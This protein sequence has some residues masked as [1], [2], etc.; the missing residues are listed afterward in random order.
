MSSFISRLS[1]EMSNMG[2]AFNDAYGNLLYGDDA[3]KAAKLV[4]IANP[5]ISSKKTSSLYYHGM[6]FIEVN[7]R[8]YV[9]SVDPKSDAHRAGVKPRD[10]VQLAL[11]LG[12]SLNHLKNNNTEAAK[13][14]LECEKDGMRT[15]CTQLK[16][17]IGESCFAENPKALDNRA[18]QE[19]YY[20]QS[21]FI[22]ITPDKN[23]N[24]S[25]SASVKIRHGVTHFM[26][27]CGGNNT[28]NN[29][30]ID[31]DETTSQQQLF[32]SPILF[33]LRRTRQRVPS[34][35]PTS[36]GLVSFRLDDECDRAADFIHRLA[37]TTLDSSSPSKTRAEIFYD[38]KNWFLPPLSTGTSTFNRRKND[39]ESEDCIK[40]S[41]EKIDNLR[42]IK[43]A[44]DIITEESSKE[45]KR[46]DE[47]ETKAIRALIQTAVGLAFIRTSKFVLGV[48]LNAGSGI[49]IARLPDGTWSPPSALGMMGAGLGLQFGLE[50]VDYIFILQTRQSLDN[51]RRGGHFTVGGNVG[52][53]VAGLGREAYGA[54]SLGGSLCAPNTPPTDNKHD[55]DSDDDMTPPPTPIAEFSHVM[56]YAKSQGLYFGV[57]LEG[58]RI[59]TRDDLN[60][61]SYKFSTGKFVHAYDVLDG[62][63][64]IPPEA[65]NLYASLHSLEYNHEISDLPRPPT[66]LREF[67]CKD[68]N[69]N[70]PSPM[71]S[72][73]KSEI[74]SLP[75]FSS[76]SEVE[77]ADCLDFESKIKD[78]L[79]GGVSVLRLIPGSEDKDG[80]TRCQ[81]RT[82]WL[83]EP[84]QGTLR[85]GFISKG[86]EE[87]IAPRQNTVRFY[88]QF[89]F[90]SFRL[91]L[92]RFIT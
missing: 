69:C 29:D 36:A 19:E 25:P 35:S 65:E 55:D 92:T 71:S 87:G 74:P 80:M 44:K 76:L 24:N 81:R 23:R 2:N 15:S 41:N 88:C 75:F 46:P 17:I 43:L 57:S 61:R 62:K 9:R 59:Y 16:H 86:V 40:L 20:T 47:L 33:V 82:L 39:I 14:G 52:A 4:F 91:D 72:S 85:I 42:S 21:S 63:V 67:F 56:A 8:A 27:M 34:A 37:N 28:T 66:I 53:A 1:S 60:C 11:V 73:N 32:S 68:W 58:N 64:P 77:T 26:G 22:N 7:D 51:F 31:R 90:L 18:G 83:M 30:T 10:C 49:I 70:Q 45:K 48:S 79:F 84:P 38:G 50:V 12:E 89:V 6:T 78:F 3:G 54:A 5:K 13:Y